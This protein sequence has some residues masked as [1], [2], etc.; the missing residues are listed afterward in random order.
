MAKRPVKL[1]FRSNK[2]IMAV[3]LVAV[4]C[5]TVAVVTLQNYLEESK[6]QFELLRQQA[7]E[8]EEQNKE[9]TSDIEGLGS[10][11]SAI[12]IAEEELGLVDPDT[13]VF[14]PETD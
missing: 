3:V 10:V 11:E 1:V 8:L 14:T 9:L 7:A 4:I 12:E 6:N 13:V 5:S 2:V